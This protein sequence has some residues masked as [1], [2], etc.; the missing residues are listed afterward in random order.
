MS[1]E[2]E[3]DKDWAVKRSDVESHDGAGPLKG[4]MVVRP[5]IAMELLNVSEDG[6]VRLLEV[7]RLPR[8][9]KIGGGRVAWRADEVQRAL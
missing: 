5:R 9:A 1:F 8:P 6:L 4:G 7:G 3:L 2:A